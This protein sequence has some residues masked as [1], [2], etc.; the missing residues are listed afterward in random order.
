MTI[1]PEYLKMY[2][3]KVHLYTF[4][5]FLNYLMYPQN[6]AV[7]VIFSYILPNPSTETVIQSGFPI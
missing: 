4:L 5:V 3:A 2:L 1:N 6:S 7:F